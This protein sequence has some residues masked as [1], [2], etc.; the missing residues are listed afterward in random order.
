V[1]APIA[2]A[3]RMKMS[4]AVIRHPAVIVYRAGPRPAARKTSP[5]PARKHCRPRRRE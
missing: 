2:T 3:S 1:P 5:A 4:P